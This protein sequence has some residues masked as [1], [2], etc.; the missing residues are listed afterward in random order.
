M[1]YDAL[2]TQQ[3]SP[4]K[5]EKTMKR[6]LIFAF[7]MCLTSQAAGAGENTPL[8]DA[9]NDEDYV[10]ASSL[11]KRG[12][13]VN[14]HDE[15][16][17]TPLPLAL[18]GGAFEV[19]DLLIAHGADVNA[20]DA[21]GWAPLHFLADFLANTSASEIDAEWIANTIDA[22]SWLFENGA[23]INAKDEY[24]NTPLHM[25]GASN[26]SVSI[27]VRL[28][29]HGADIEAKNVL[30]ATP[31]HAATAT[32]GAILSRLAR[33]GISD[34]KIIA[35]MR[36]FGIDFTASEVEEYRE[37]PAPNATKVAAL[38]IKKG[39]DVHAT[40]KFGSTPLHGAILTDDAETITLL[41]KAGA[42]LEATENNGNTPLLIAAYAN[43]LT[44][45]KLL[46]R[47]GASMSAK[48]ENYQTPLSMAKS[49][50]HWGIVKLL[51]AAAKQ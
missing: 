50:K 42:Y 12:A 20:K 37:N 32:T 10:K 23:N 29:K 8:H 38:L 11:I 47:A 41:I 3:H 26:A 31:L 22:V 6:S 5:E 14:A 16:G 24:G 9:L 17:V 43:A 2:S 15:D 19:A 39:A 25:T 7:F 1:V 27:V 40:D 36:D 34:T 28:I 45:T 21:D 18:I 13:D 4:E 44:A 30:G 33:L 48:N 49:K 51:E 46:I 35:H